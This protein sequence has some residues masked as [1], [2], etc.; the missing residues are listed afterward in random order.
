MIGDRDDRLCRAGPVVAELT[1]DQ[2]LV[3]HDDDRHRPPLRRLIERLVKLYA[4]Q[5]A[6]LAGERPLR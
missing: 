4:D 1:E 6:L 5:A 3:V 2:F